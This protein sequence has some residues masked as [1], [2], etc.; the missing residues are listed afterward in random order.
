MK[1]YI[2]HVPE[3]MSK[4]A[5]RDPP[6]KETVNAVLLTVTTNFKARYRNRFEF[7]LNPDASQGI[8]V[9]IKCRMVRKA[10]GKISSD[11][12]KCECGLLEAFE[13]FHRGIFDNM[14]GEV[15]DLEKRMKI[16]HRY[17]RLL[18]HWDGSN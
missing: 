2:T 12:K 5:A 4:L 13:Q 14:M 1:L 8:N 18:E 17:G 6:S 9:V 3:V 16:V 7:V 11:G 15:L 10:D